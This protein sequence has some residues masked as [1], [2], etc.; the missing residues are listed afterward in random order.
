MTDARIQNENHI[1]EGG[2]GIDALNGSTSRTCYLVGVVQTPFLGMEE[3]MNLMAEQDPSEEMAGC[4]I[5]RSRQIIF[6]A[7]MEMMYGGP[8]ADVLTGGRVP[9]V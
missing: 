5:R 2:S 1:I 3:A 7:M 8:G 9:I 4:I 6:K